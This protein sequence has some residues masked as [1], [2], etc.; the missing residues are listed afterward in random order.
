MKYR[1][2]FVTNSSSSSF[3]LNIE[4]NLKNG[5]YITFRGNGGTGETG[6]ID[7]FDSDAIVRVSPK[8]LGTAKDVEEMISLLINGVIDFNWWGDEQEVKIF[9]KS[10]PVM[11][12]YGGEFDAYEFIEEIRQKIN[13]MEDIESIV[14]EGNEY[15]YM[16]YLRSYTYNL[17]SKKYT[18]QESGY[19]FE[20]DGSSGGDLTFDTSDCDIEYFD[21]DE[22]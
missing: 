7:Y 15:N 18:G 1:S 4:L 11:S 19:E 5:D 16:N 3:I 10:N 9:E 12:E 8:E 17:E 20:K 22:E 6:R 14:I 2:D 21:Q 13:S